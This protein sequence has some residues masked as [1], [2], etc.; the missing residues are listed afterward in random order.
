MIKKY[1]TLSSIWFSD[2][3]LLV[4][5]VLL[6]VRLFVIQPLAELGY[7]HSIFT[8]VFFSLIMLS[9]VL[10]V[11]RTGL[12]AVVVGG[13]AGAELVNSVGTTFAF[14]QSP[15]SGGEDS[16]LRFSRNLSLCGPDTRFPRRSHH[17]FPGG[18]AQ[19]LFTSVGSHVV[20]GST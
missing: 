11:F 2:Q 16:G 3:M 14:R 17:D 12:G 10:A 20:D 6:L 13:F 18:R 1:K 4:L 8:G 15:L 5:L 19:S 9:G 7:L